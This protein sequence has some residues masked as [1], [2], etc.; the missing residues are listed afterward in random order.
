M[1]QP[2]DLNRSVETM[3]S[4]V[5]RVLDDLD[6]W[7]K[8][9]LDGELPIVVCRNAPILCLRC[10]TVI[11]PGTDAVLA[12]AGKYWLH[13][14]CA[15]P[16]LAPVADLPDDADAIPDPAQLALD[17]RPALRLVHS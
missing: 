12:L 3:P 17:L 4:F 13:T 8:R 15:V 16:R 1:T 2:I 6:D 9:T 10:N 11:V 5:A 14:W 7:R